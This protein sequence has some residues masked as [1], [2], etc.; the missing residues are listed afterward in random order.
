[1]SKLRISHRLTAVGLVASLPMACITW[2]LIVSAID[3]DIDFGSQEKRGN[4]YQQPLE[5]LLQLVGDHQ[6]VAGQPASREGQKLQEIQRQIEAALQRLRA[7]NTEL[8]T[9][10]QF[11]PEGLGKRQREHCTAQ[12]VSQEW[13]E[14]KSR[15]PGLNAET[16]ADKHAHLLNDL[17][18]M[19]THAGDTSNLIL[20]PDLDSYYLMDATLLALPQNLD[21]L[22]K[23][24]VWLDQLPAD[25]PLAESNK[26]QLAVHV[27]Q[28]KEADLDRINGDVQ[29]ALNEDANFYG[30]S[31]TLQTNLPPA[32][33]EY[34]QAVE[35]LAERLEQV[36]GAAPLSNAL[37]QAVE[38]AGAARAANS[39]LWQTGDRELD[40]LLDIR[41]ASYEFHRR[42]S[43]L[44]SVVALFISG[45][46]VFF[47][48][49]NINTVLGDLAGTLSDDAERIAAAAGQLTSAS[50]MLADGAS[51]QA[52]SLEQTGSS[53]EE[54]ASMTQRNAEGA[55]QVKE[56]GLR[57]RTAGDSAVTDM[58]AMNTAMDAIKNSSS[59]IAKII[60]TIDEIAFQTNIL[61]LNAA[62]EAA[63]AGEAGLGFAVVA[64][65]VRSL[66]GRCSHAAQETSSK[67]AD[68][69]RKSQNG[70]EISSKV[71]KSL[72]E[73]ATRI[74]EVG[75]VAEV[76]AVASKEQSQGI[77][78]INQAV[79]EMDRVTQANAASAEESASA[80]QALHAQATQLREVA[81]QLL[82]LIG[83]NQ[84]S[85]SRSARP[86][87]AAGKS[88][89]EAIAV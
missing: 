34:A 36:G 86:K 46:V 6:W 47:I 20:D 4:R 16:V 87:P 82:N 65:A 73:I 35:R 12:N 83:R 72:E 60:R 25:Q 89:I 58:Q 32:A 31:P 69:I 51:N 88:S 26:V 27:A 39:R 8:E 70:V 23:I 21:R 44:L 63:R 79:V 22:G 45:G 33:K 71:G 9:A 66:A 18:V 17:R 52:A 49:R 1:M 59:E 5:E 74:R 50:Q 61:S 3:K 41:I 67:I 85:G 30:A 19:I 29:T 56:L 48:I 10:L 13:S 76:V 2:Y 75:E 40:R 15:L 11:T 54:M 37:A 55:D 28:L 24:R 80:S 7:V 42:L 14:L 43:L 38:A 81:G 68:S 64:D 84:R 57:A 78:Q 62:V 77:G 53:L